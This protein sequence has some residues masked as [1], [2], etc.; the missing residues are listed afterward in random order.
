MAASD[1][2]LLGSWPSPFAMRVHIALKLKGI[3]YEFHE[4]NLLEARSEILLKS[5][6]VHK[7][8]PVLIHNNKPICESQV[9]VE[10]VD[11][12]FTSGPPILPSDPY[13]RAIARF[14]AAYIDGELFSMMRVTVRGKDEE[15]KKAAFEG[16][17]VGLEILEGAFVKISDG[18]GFFGGEKIGFVDIVLGSQLGWIKVTEKISGTAFINEAKTPGLYG[19]AER[20]CSDVVV[21]DLMPETDKLL[22]YAI[23]AF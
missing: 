23:A 18:K 9:I 19:W 3:S 8:I 2:K 4:E 13:D 12:V 10:Y 1:M 15:E 5:N 20:F 16:V 6:P 11:E 14:W 22:E 7:K 17:R 21:K